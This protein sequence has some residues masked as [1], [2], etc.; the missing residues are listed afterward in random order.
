MTEYERESPATQLES[1]GGSS[2]D[3]LPRRDD[4]PGRQDTAGQT[5]TEREREA[6]QEV[7][8]S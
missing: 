1:S 8:E 6:A 5:V 7:R 2:D 4:E 3:P